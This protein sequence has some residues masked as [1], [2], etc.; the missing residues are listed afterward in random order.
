M[1]IRL[2]NS[3]LTVLAVQKRGYAFL[4]ARHVVG[5]WPEFTVYITSGLHYIRVI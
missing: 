1:E 4:T 2:L 5:W 3:Y